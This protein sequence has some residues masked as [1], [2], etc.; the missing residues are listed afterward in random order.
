MFNYSL[1][2]SYKKGYG[3]VAWIPSTGKI[4]VPGS[5][6]DI[7]LAHKDALYA[8]SFMTPFLF[9]LVIPQNQMKF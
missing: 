3:G 8:R 2:R 7:P 9:L 1:C 5:E 4:G 6:I